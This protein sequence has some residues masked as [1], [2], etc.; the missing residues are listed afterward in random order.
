MWETISVSVGSS[1]YRGRYRVEGRKVLLEWRGGRL[2]EWCGVL[3]PGVVAA[4]T[5]RNLAQ[6]DAAIAA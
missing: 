1:T 4:N 2:S 3:R 5:L 6:R